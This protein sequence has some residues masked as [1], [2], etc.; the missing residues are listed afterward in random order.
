MVEH[1]L[2]SSGAN[3]SLCFQN[4]ALILTPTKFS[5]KLKKKKIDPITLTWISWKKKK[6][7]GDS[8]YKAQ[9]NFDFNFFY[10]P[11]HC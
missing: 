6:Y 8:S 5:L 11:S 4:V 1:K 9:R 10:R 3:T 2:Q 7:Q